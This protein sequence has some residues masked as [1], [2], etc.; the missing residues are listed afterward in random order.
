MYNSVDI[1]LLIR[2]YCQHIERKVRG[3]NSNH[4]RGILMLP[5]SFRTSLEYVYDEDRQYYRGMTSML[6]C[7]LC[8]TASL[9]LMDQYRYCRGLTG[10]LISLSHLL[11]ASM[12]DHLILGIEISD[13]FDIEQFTF[14]IFSGPTAQFHHPL[15][16][17]LAVEQWHSAND[18]LLI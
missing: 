10:G 16:R 7:N 18:W 17:Y 2:L 12:S 14:D 13:P 5:E 3:P 9:S 8:G 4:E 6:L 11:P 15:G 1:L